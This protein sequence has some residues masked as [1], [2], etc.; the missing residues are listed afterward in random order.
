MEGKPHSKDQ[1]TRDFFR[2]F[3]RMIDAQNEPFY[4]L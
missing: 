1:A 4:P 2:I 3:F